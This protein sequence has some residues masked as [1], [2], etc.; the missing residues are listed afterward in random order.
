MKP[1]CQKSGVRKTLLGWTST[2]GLTPGQNQPT[3]SYMKI[4]RHSVPV[5]GTSVLKMG[6]AVSPERWIIT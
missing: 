6:A 3:V 1:K 2:V 4:L 5:D